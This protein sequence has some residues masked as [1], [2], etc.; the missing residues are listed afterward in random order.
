M[1]RTSVLPRRRAVAGAAALAIGLAAVIAGPGVSSSVAAP[2][3]KAAT[4]IKH[5]VVIFGGN[6]SF[7]HYFGTYPNATNTSRQR[8]TAAPGTP[9]VNGLS[10][11]LL[12][13]N[14][15]MRPAPQ[16]GSIPNKQRS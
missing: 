10:G 8:F 5:L 15:K 14:P 12:T 9:A 16:R 7:D 13:A 1:S 11:A 2:K 3:D 4:L 6:V